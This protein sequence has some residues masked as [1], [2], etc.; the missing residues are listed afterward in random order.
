[1]S[2]A[3]DSPAQRRKLMKEIERLA[4]GG[5]GDFRHAVGT[6]SHLR[7]RRLPLSAGGTEAR[8]APERQLSRGARQDDRLLRS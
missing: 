3:T 2:T 6:L 7:A 5:G 8:S 4:L 1:M